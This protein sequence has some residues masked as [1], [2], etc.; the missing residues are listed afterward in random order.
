MQKLG[1]KMKE[2]IEKEQK[3][4]EEKEEHKKKNGRA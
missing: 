4:L 2:S 3:A 1:P